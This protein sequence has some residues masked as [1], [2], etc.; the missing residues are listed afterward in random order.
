MKALVTGVAGFIGSSLAETLIESGTSVVGIDSFL[1]Y[2]PRPF[3]ERNLERLSKSAGFELREG[4]LQRM[5]LPR[6]FMGCDRVFHLAAQAGVRASWGAEF[7]IY[8]DNN[9]LATQ[10]LLEAGVGAN[11]RS[12]VF[13]SSSSVYGDST[14]L[15]MM[16]DVP[17][18]PVSPYGVSK[19]AAEKLCELYFVNHQV[20]TVSLRYFTVYGPRQ[21]PDM[22][23]HRL[24]KCALVGAPFRLY[25]DGRQTRDFTF[26]TD[27]VAATIAASERGRGGAVYNVGGGSRVSMLEVIDTVREVTGREVRIQSEPRQKGDMRDTYADT[28]A[29]RRELGYEPTTTLGEGLELEWQWIRGLSGS[30]LASR[31]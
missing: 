19:L 10:Q 3:K 23:F 18:H 25:G 5:D 15:P 27:A 21:R 30:M 24:L 2:Y 31:E 13:A 28:G 29:A 6:L 4:P 11:L 22:A 16:E 12:F 20:P 8:T 9:I 17:L 14:P 7:G 1:D 26:I